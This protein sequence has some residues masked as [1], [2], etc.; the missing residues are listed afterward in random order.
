M[1]GIVQFPPAR[2]SKDLGGHMPGSVAKV[3]ASSAVLSLTLCGAHAWAQPVARRSVSPVLVEASMRAGHVIGVVKDDQGSAVAGVA[4]TAIGTTQ[5]QAKTDKAGHFRLALVPGDYILRAARDGYVSPY[6][7]SV[8]IRASAEIERNITITRQPGLPER[9]VLVAGVG[10]RAPDDVAPLPVES[11]VTPIAQTDRLQAWFLR[12]LPRTV[13]RD[14]GASGA[15]E[16]IEPRRTD[17]RYLP[18][19]LDWAVTESAR[20]ATSLFSETDFSGQLN[21]LTTSAVG[22]TTGW[23]GGL[24]RGVAYLSVG[25]AVGTHGDWRVRGALSTGGLASWVA[26]SE[27]EARDVQTHAFRVGMSYGAQRYADTSDTAIFTTGEPTRHVASLYGFDRWRINPAFEL[28]YGLRADRYDYVDGRNFLSPRIGVR[29]GVMPRTFLVASA[30][31]AVIAP[32]IDEFLP[33]PASGPWLPPERTFTSL[34][35]GAGFAPERVQRV[36]VGAERAFG[37]IG[38]TRTLGVRWFNEQTRNQLA[39]IF[40]HGVAGGVGHYYVA[41]AGDVTLHGWAVKADGWLTSRINAAV[42]YSFS[43]ASW[44]YGPQAAAIAAVLPSALRPSHEKLHDLTT[45]VRAQIPETQT[46]LFVAYRVNSAFSRPDAVGLDPMFDGRFDV[47]LRQAL[48]FQPIAGSRL[49]LLVAVNNLFRDTASDGIRAGAF[50][51]ELLTVR[52]PRRLLGGVQV[53]F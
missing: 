29:L 44:E 39:T 32:G 47:Q 11:M 25:A 31:S 21:M 8:R 30:S 14:G 5:A 48:P 23:T 53:R 24:P 27:Y 2:L 28:D 1:G 51:D 40:G 38:K 34:V 3:V 22:A 33:P 17:F 4:V 26:L 12:H 9:R 20:A 45:T 52:T 43:L 7:E 50:Y 15:S 41:T 18:S 13:L 42:E 49:E 16:V 19:F 10:M 6:R 46:S 37:P 35:D 36:E